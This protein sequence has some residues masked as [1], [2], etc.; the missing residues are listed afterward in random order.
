VAAERGYPKA[1]SRE[2]VYIKPLS[3]PIPMAP[4]QCSVTETQMVGVWGGGFGGLKAKGLSAFAPLP[5]E[6]PRVRNSLECS[7]LGTSVNTGTFFILCLLYCMHA[8]ARSHACSQLLIKEHGGFVVEVKVV[9]NAPKGDTFYVLIQWAAVSDGTNCSK[10][11]ISFKVGACVPGGSGKAGSR[12][13]LQF[14][15]M[16]LPRDQ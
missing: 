12:C 2:V 7:C 14:A 13:I 1:K 10:I 9:A 15:G 16:P 6:A 3:I 5:S 8:L 11:R 4:K